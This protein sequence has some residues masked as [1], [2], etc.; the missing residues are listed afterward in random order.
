ME[1]NSG[2]RLADVTIHF[3]RFTS[4]LPSLPGDATCAGAA[5][6]GAEDVGLCRAVVFEVAAVP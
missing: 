6:V 3:L 5:N 4:G 2:E 1:G